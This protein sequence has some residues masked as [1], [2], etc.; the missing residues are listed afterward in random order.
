MVVRPQPSFGRCDGQPA[1]CSSRRGLEVEQG[2]VPAQKEGNAIWHAWRP[3]LFKIK[4]WGHGVYDL[5]VIVLEGS[6]PLVALHSAYLSIRV[7][8]IGLLSTAWYCTIVG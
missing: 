7:L 3:A 2:L 4:D 8:G 5:M 6:G 1:F